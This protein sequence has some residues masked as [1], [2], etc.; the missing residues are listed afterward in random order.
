MHYSQESDGDNDSE[1]DVQLPY[2]A[3]DDCA[4]FSNITFAIQNFTEF[5]FLN[6]PIKNSFYILNEKIDTSSLANNI[7][8]PPKV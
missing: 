2:K 5:S 7:W 3:K 6:F 1:K 4:T 8:Q